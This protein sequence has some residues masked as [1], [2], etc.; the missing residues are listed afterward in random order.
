MA[1]VGS[2]IRVRTDKDSDFILGIAQ[3][4]SDTANIADPGSLG[5]SCRS[6]IRGISIL[7]DQN[8]A[9]ELKFFN[10]NRFNTDAADLDQVPFIGGWGF[11]AA[12]GTQIAATGPYYYYIDGLYIPYHC[13]DF[14]YPSAANGNKGHGKIVNGVATPQ[15]QIHM[16]LINRSATAKNAGATGEIVITLHMEPSLG[17]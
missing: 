1:Q 16:M 7:S 13:T 8:L 10:T 11:Q 3:N 4:A 12:D 14:D 17:W 2:I 15:G 6:I 5:A 9:W